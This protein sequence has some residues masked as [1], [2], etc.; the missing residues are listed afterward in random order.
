MCGEAR[1]GNGVG[2]ILLK[3][4]DAPGGLIGVNFVEALH[5]RACNSHWVACGPRDQAGAEIRKLREG[6]VDQVRHGLIEAVFAHVTDDA[7]DFD[8][9]LAL[10]KKDFSAHGLL[11]GPVMLRE[12]MVD[13]GDARS[14]LA[15]APLEHAATEK[16]N[17]QSSKII[18]TDDIE[19]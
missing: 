15:I 10:V 13:D 5:D 6:N 9:E 2:A 18:G 1:G 16:R 19:F 4:L 12:G 8:R 17:A 11:V 14:A 7:N 3:R